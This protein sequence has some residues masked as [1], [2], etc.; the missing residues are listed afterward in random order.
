[1]RIFCKRGHLQS[2]KNVYIRPNKTTN[3]K[4]CMRM[5]GKA[6][7]KNH[8]WI[9]T[10]TQSQQRCNNPKHK[11]YKYYG[12][13]GIKMLMKP[14]DLKYLWFRDKVYLMKKPSI[15][16]INNNGNYTLK[17]CQYIELS[18]NVGKDRMGEKCCNSKLTEKQVIQIR[19][20]YN[21]DNVNQTEIAR[22]FKTIPSNICYIVNYKTWKHLK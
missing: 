2:K 22:K 4:I 19:K 21:E 5:K 18:E 6:W 14:N 17:N 3:C 16:R 8:P 11:F 20:L 10:Y 7:Y 12:G 13:R 15:D 1:M 9:I